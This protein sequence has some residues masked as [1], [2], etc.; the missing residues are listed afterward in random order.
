MKYH[1]RAIGQ[2]IMQSLEMARYYTRET[3]LTYLEN[4]IGRKQRKIQ[5]I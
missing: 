5:K 4:I 3:I 2:T 1:N